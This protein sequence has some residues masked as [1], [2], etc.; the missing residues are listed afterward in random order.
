MSSHVVVVAEGHNDIKGAKK[1]PNY[2]KALSHGAISANSSLKL[3][4]LN[5][6]IPY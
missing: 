5:G 6:P 2:V 1:L 3:N 4:V